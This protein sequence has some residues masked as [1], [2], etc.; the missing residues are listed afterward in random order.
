MHPGDRLPRPPCAGNNILELGLY[1][2]VRNALFNVNQIHGGSGLGT[3]FRR[4]GDEVESH[5]LQC[6]SSDV[7][8]NP[9]SFLNPGQVAVGCLADGQTVFAGLTRFHNEKLPHGEYVIVRYRFD[10]EDTS[11]LNLKVRN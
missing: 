11:K 2:T 10:E 9:G 8:D 6:S 4:S 5:E 1:A 3:V 7:F